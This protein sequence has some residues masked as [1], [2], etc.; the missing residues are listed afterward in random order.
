MN[1]R[2]RVVEMRRVPASELKANPKN[3]REHPPE[4]QRA[5]QGVLEEVGIA[6][7]LLARETPD[8]LELIDGHLRTEMN[9]A[10]EWPV[11]ILD[12]D[13]N[14][15]D[16][17]LASVDPIGALAKTNTDALKALLGQIETDNADLDS[18][19]S[20]L[21]ESLPQ[22]I[23]EGETDPDDVPE[24]DQVEKRCKPGDLWTLGRH[25]L[26]CGDSTSAEEV[27]RLMGGETVDVLFTD[28]PYGMD[29]DTDYTKLP[30][31]QCESVTY[32]KVKGDDQLFDAA[33]MLETFKAAKDVFLWG[34]DWYYETLPRGGSWIVWDK[35]SEAS[36][37]LIGNHFEMLWSIKRHRREIIRHQWS[38]FTARNPDFRREHPTEKPIAVLADVIGKHS[39]AG[40]LIVDPFAGSGTTITAAEQT[41]RRCYS[42][43]FV[44]GYC[45]VILARWEAFTGSKAE[46][47]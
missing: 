26:L 38:G 42:V 18:L 19:L 1:W 34:A 21:K 15:A 47:A 4:Q 16:V 46:R 30:E 35:R 44:P 9:D 8:G 11:L 45:D 31:T 17:L 10:T 22:D 3:W 6:G 39:K 2:D 40:A 43:E 23:M 32:Q 37:G 14:E 5:M 13:E 7:A 41:G 24:G 33:P 25:R 12:V 27:E 28:P 29:L 20:E 36:D